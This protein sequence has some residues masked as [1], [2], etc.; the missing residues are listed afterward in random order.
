MSKEGAVKTT[1][2]QNTSAKDTKTDDFSLQAEEGKDIV[3][4]LDEQEW[5]ERIFKIHN[6]QVKLQYM[7][8]SENKSGMV[9]INSSSSKDISTLNYIIDRE[10]IELEEG[11]A[12]KPLSLGGMVYQ[13]NEEDGSNSVV[14]FSPGGKMVL[15]SPNLGE[16][17]ESELAMMHLISIRHS[18]ETTDNDDVEISA[19]LKDPVY[20]SPKDGYNVE[21]KQGEYTKYANSDNGTLK[22]WETRITYNDDILMDKVE[23]EINEQGVLIPSHNKELKQIVEEYSETVIDDE[24]LKAEFD[25][26]GDGEFLKT[27]YM[28]TVGETDFYL[29][30][31]DKLEGKVNAD[32]AYAIFHGTSVEL[33]DIVAENG[34]YIQAKSGQA[35]INGQN[36]NM[37][38]VKIDDSDSEELKAVTA[39]T[40]IEGFSATMEQYRYTKGNRTSYEAATIKSQLN[41]GK[42]TKK[43][44]KSKNTPE[45]F[46]QFSLGAGELVDDEFQDDTRSLNIAAS[47]DVEIKDVGIG[48]TRK[49]SVYDKEIY[50]QDGFAKLE[51]AEFEFLKEEN[52]NAHIKGSG[53][54][55]I[56]EIP[57]SLTMKDNSVIS[58]KASGTEAVE[59]VEFDIDSNG[60][61]SATFEEDA[62]ANLRMSNVTEEEE[63]EEKVFR[64]FVLGNLSITNG[65][66]NAGSIRMDRGIKIAKEEEEDEEKSDSESDSEGNK[67]LKIF[68]CK[69]QGSLANKSEEASID[70]TGIKANMKK[71]TFGTYK[72]EDFMGFLG[73]EIDYPNGKLAVSAKKEAKTKDP[74]SSFFSFAGQSVTDGVSV[75]TGIPG[76]QIK[77]SLKPS[78]NIGGEVGFE[79]ER[80]TPF[81]EKWKDKDELKLKGNIKTEGG[82]SIEASAGVE[83]GVPVLAN[84]DF[85]VGGEL[86]ATIEGELEGSTKLQFNEKQNKLQQSNDFEFDGKLSGALKG[87]LNLSSNVKFLFLNAQLFKIALVKKELGKIEFGGSGK[88]DHT[89]KG[90]TKGW[91]INSAEF[92][93][94]WFSEEIAKKYKNDKKEEGQKQNDEEFKKLMSNSEKETEDAWAALCE[95]KRKREDTLILL[96]EKD[97]QSLEK[98]I[99][100]ITAEV[101]TKLKRFIN[102]LHK[103][104]IIL[105]TDEKEQKK[106]IDEINAQL[107]KYEEQVGLSTEVFKK[108]KMGGFDKEKYRKTE[109]PTE[110]P[111]DADRKTA[112]KIREQQE[113]N[114]EKDKMAAIDL[115]IARILGEVSQEN[116]DD[117]ERRHDR[118]IEGSTIFMKFREKDEKLQQEIYKSETRF[119]NTGSLLYESQSSF[120]SVLNEKAIYKSTEYKRP[121]DKSEKKGV[122]FERDLSKFPEPFKKI[123]KE[124]KDI[125][126]K[127]LLQYVLENKKPDGS[128]LKAT[129]EQKLELLKKSFGF[130]EHLKLRYLLFSK[131]RVEAAKKINNGLARET[132]E[133]F[134]N[135]FSTSLDDVVSGKNVIDIFEEIEKLHNN[136]EGAK[137]KLKNAEE[138]LSVTNKSQNEITRKQNEYYQKLADLKRDS[139]AALQDKSFDSTAAGNVIKTYS[140][141]YIDKMKGRMEVF[142]GK[143]SNNVFNWA[144]ANKDRVREIVLSGS[145]E[146]DSKGPVELPKPIRK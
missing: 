49:S 73:G 133:K 76:V 91:S 15:K 82:A 136:L 54:V 55:K 144:I 31:P 47:K 109:V 85:T 80:G 66:L 48:M 102:I 113:A 143:N 114:T 38:D 27:Y 59:D 70:L 67:L 7:E 103:S 83:L 119:V 51:D 138:M 132:G 120:Y 79:V 41:Y 37:T 35:V 117:I 121:Q 115:M 134:Q 86:G 46:A 57:Y 130:G 10:T 9:P 126:M 50:T 4:D 101:R 14:F 6:Q 98:Q 96:D 11:I 142:A 22:F 88:K 64:R 124:N 95:I 87:A 97:K 28:I 141:D 99:A 39:E 69:M 128:E 93:A 5:K 75:P 108:A 94:Q 8:E 135:I 19:Y 92:S 74:E 100:T 26:K 127:E 61:L 105:A 30:N 3:T 23:T 56:L 145:N 110:I 36:V 111:K 32:S 90:L 42:N 52:S 43:P 68:D 107:L 146:Q 81:D 125:T 106:L 62:E 21:L 44:E 131:E 137:E 13:K 58:G 71:T 89:Q 29:K 1:K 33:K 84:I 45:D 77:F 24:E 60:N 18:E 112:K 140:D 12:I 104:Q 53:N 116:L 16:V 20:I 17:D 63:E 72:V 78:A 2:P 122:L 65:Y 34:K 118:R 129:P 139:E 25:F 40:L 123:V